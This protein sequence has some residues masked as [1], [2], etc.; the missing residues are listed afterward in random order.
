MSTCASCVWFD[1]FTADERSIYYPNEGDG[2]CRRFPPVGDL[3][4]PLTHD[5]GRC[6]EHNHGD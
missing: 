5:D 6:G 4:Q 3:G 1:R 2:W